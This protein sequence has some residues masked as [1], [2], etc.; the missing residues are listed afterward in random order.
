[1]DIRQLQ[2]FVA[3]A[4]C[5]SFS[6]AARR[7][8]IAQPALSRQIRDLEADLGCELL[9]RSGKGASLTPAGERLFPYALSLLRQLEA[10]PD[11][12]ADSD[13]DVSGRVGVGIPTSASEVLSRPLL[14]AAT[15]ELPKVRLHLLEL[16]DGNLNDLV[17]AGRLDLS[18]LY[19]PEPSPHLNVQGILIEQL[20]LVGAPAAFAPKRRHVRVHEL[21]QYRLALPA[22]FHSLRRL[23]ET[24]ATR[25]GVQ[26][27]VGLEVESL[28]IIKMA[29][30]EGLYFSV[31]P[32]AAVAKEVAAGTLRSVPVIEPAI[33]RSVC[34]VSSAVRGQTR[35]CSEVAKLILRIARALRQSGEWKGSN[36]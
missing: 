14:L 10:V 22:A 20:E 35:A 25:H 5:G 13:R 30:E 1:M 29:L 28:S 15:A 31:L 27:D 21:G 12:V 8:H 34:L 16:A 23:V 17:Q 18:I 24:T 9:R 2:T 3:V 4:E 11:V 32:R 36:P 6:E 33:S 19:D 26:I 7:R